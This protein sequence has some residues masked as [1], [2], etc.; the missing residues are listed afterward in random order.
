[1][2]ADLAGGIRVQDL[3]FDDKPQPLPV[4][5]TTLR[6][7]QIPTHGGICVRRHLEEQIVMVMVEVVTAG[8]HLAPWVTSFR[9][10]GIFFCF[11]VKARVALFPGDTDAAR[12]C[13]PDD[14]NGNCQ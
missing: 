5:F 12:V 2:T 14:G 8:C 3:A 1:M 6:P 4:L 13:S 11:L 7:L 9:S 10:A